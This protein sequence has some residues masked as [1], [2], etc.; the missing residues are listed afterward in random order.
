MPLDHTN[1]IRELVGDSVLVVDPIED[2]CLVN[3]LEHGQQVIFTG[4]NPIF[5]TA[6]NQ[7]MRGY[8]EAALAGHADEATRLFNELHAARDVRQ[9]WIQDRW[10]STQLIPIAVIKHW[11]AELGMT[12]GPTPSPLPSLSQDEAD[13][14]QSELVTVGLVS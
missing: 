1:K 14:L 11:T 8:I 10:K 12:G 9:R 3:M 7:P 4:D 5:D 13:D 2:R 6:T